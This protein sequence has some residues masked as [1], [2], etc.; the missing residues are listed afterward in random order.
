MI[1]SL[2][3]LSILQLPFL[4]HCKID[5]LTMDHILYSANIWYTLFSEVVHSYFPKTGT[6]S[7]SDYKNLGITNPTWAICGASAIVFSGWSSLP[8]GRGA[9]PGRCRMY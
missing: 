1:Q 3:F 2:R 6:L 8:I 7:V 9:R 4:R 5:I